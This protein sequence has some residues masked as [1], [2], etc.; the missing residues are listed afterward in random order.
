MSKDR[1]R[2]I[3]R[4]EAPDA[5]TVREAFRV[6]GSKYVRIWAADCF[7]VDDPPGG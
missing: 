5:E 3:C 4:F 2:S 6:S 7:S 1:S